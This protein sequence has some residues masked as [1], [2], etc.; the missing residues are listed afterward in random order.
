MDTSIKVMAVGDISLITRNNLPPFSKVEAIFRKKDILF[1]N[2]ET[3]LS[4]YGEK[5]QK[6][7][8]LYTSPDKAFYLKK[9]GFDV[10]NVANNHTLDL[11]TTGFNET[12][13]ALYRNNIAPVGG[14]NR[15]FNR[16]YA[17]IEKKGIRCCFMGYELRGFSDREKGV[18][19]NKIQK[20]KILADIDSAK[21]ISDIVLVSLHWGE[22][23]VHF[24]SPKQIQ[25]ARSLIDAG[26]TVIL[27]GHPHVFQGI[28]RYKNG[29]IVY[30]LANFQFD[31]DHEGVSFERLRNTLIL[32]MDITKNGVEG[33]TI[34][35]VRIGEDYVPY[36]LEGTE[37]KQLLEN[38]AKTSQA[39]CEG[40][41]T[42]RIW[43]E[44]IGYE[45]LRGNTSAWVTRIRR[46]GLKNML[47]FIKWCMSPFV[48]KCYMGTMS[49]YLKRQFS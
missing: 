7:T 9:A 18:F 15:M 22:E 1:G 38:M 21:A 36:V 29:L 43:F 16:P 14:A 37:A 47:P 34:A 28:E 48:M 39:I 5:A 46:Y 25:F 2:L 11:G 8:L 17:V 33:Y 35:P 40:R 26:A 23:N 3:T 24:P 44:E 19:I 13:E 12:M 31:Y 41:V 30:S 20:E 27:G 49:K 4:L 32:E 45:Y 42:N 6:R 10:L